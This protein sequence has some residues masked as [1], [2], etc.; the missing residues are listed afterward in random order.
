MKLRKIFSKRKMAIGLLAGVYLFTWIPNILADD[1]D[2]KKN[3]IAIHD[4]SSGEYKKNCSE[5]HADIR[6]AQS[7][8]PSIPNVHVAMFDFA[9]GKPGDDKQCIWCHKTVDLVQGSAGN[10]RKQVD[11]TLCTMCHGPAGPGKPFHQV[12][13]SELALDG[14]ALYDLA[15]AACHRDL[16]NSKV[17]GESAEEIQEKIDKNKGGMRPLSV[18]SA[19]DINAIA[20]ALAE[21][22]GDDDDDDDS[23]DDD[24]GDDDSDDG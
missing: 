21:S 8:Q 2:P 6:N 5:C 20:A 16:A 12:N 23:D 18:L 13:L 9:P 10:L 3:I 11:A 15:C 1:F 4:S 14:P 19:E 17:S 7:L 24:S 22:G